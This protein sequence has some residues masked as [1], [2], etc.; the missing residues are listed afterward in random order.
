MSKIS[1]VIPVFNEAESLIRLYE[2]LVDTLKDLKRDYE[3]LFIDDGSSDQTPKVLKGLKESDDHVFVVRLRRN[4]GKSIAL[5][6]GFQQAQGDVVISLDGDGQDDPCE[7]G[8]FLDKIDEGWDLVCGWKRNRK[9]PV[10]KKMASWLYN[11]AI[12]C[13]SRLNV[14]DN[15]CGFK[16][17]RSAVIKTV[18]VY[19]ELHRF[20]PMLAHGYGFKICEIEIHHR[21][22]LFG[23]SK[24]GAGRYLSGLF[25]FLSV[26]FLSNYCRKPMHFL[27]KISLFFFFVGNIFLGYTIYMKFV[28]GQTGDRPAL[29]LA[30]FLLGFSV[31]MFIFGIL[32]E[33]LSYIHQRSQFSPSDF[34]ASSSTHE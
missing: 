33:F 21:P 9:D 29:A 11:A 7:I 13:V 18:R 5:A 31:Q 16:A 3:I 20:I 6:I 2:E 26:I 32:A 27:G 24:F 14:H 34:I 17:Y 28:L 30:F 19:G 25:D 10:E 1:L 12:R 23:K 8:R 15:N 4:F 22:R